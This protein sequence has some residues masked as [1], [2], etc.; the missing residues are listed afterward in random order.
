VRTNRA[1]LK[2][3]GGMLFFN[4]GMWMVSPLYIIYFVRG[5]GATDSW[6]GLRTTLSHI[7]VVVG[8]WLWRRILQR[9][10]ER[11]ALLIARPLLASYAFLVALVPDLNVLLAIGFVINV[12]GPGV[13]LSQSVI[14]LDMLPRE[15]RHTW[16]AIHSILMNIGAFVCPLIGVAL[17]E[18]WGIVPALLLGG[19]LRMAGAVLFSVLD[20]TKGR[21][22]TTA[23]GMRPRLFGGFRR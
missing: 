8:Y 20:L 23:S 13:G 21:I 16:M 3:N 15:R 17:A 6:V 4:L 1:F 22:S 2:L 7:G 18:R 10:G 9:I 11:K 5:L 14:L 19:S 12:V